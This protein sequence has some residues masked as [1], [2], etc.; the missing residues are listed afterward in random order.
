M[1]IP[2][3][4]SQQSMPD[5]AKRVFQGKIFDVYQWQQE[6]YDGSRQTFEKLRRADTTVVIPVT[7]DNRIILT[8]Q[9]QPGKKPFIG[10]AGGRLEDGEEVIEGARRELEEETGYTSD[11]FELLDAMQ[12][13]SKIDWVIYFVVAR[14]CRLV[15]GQKLD[16]GE[17][18]SLQIVDFET[19]IDMLAFR[20]IPHEVELTIMALRAKLD[21]ERMQ[22]LRKKIL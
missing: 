22:A 3:P 10:F 8:R 20:E 9:E 13:V 19:M 2:R 15:S 4:A 11:T 21:P 18:I 16:A 17:K 14:N 5:N 6:M 12:P 1:T 7:E